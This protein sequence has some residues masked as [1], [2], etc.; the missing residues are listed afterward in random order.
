MKKYI[1]IIS[2]VLTALTTFCAKADDELRKW[3]G[4]FFAGVNVGIGEDFAVKDYVTAIDSKA[5]AGYSL[6]AE[7]RR[8]L[9][10]LPVDLGLRLSFSKVGYDVEWKAN[11]NSPGMW[12][13]SYVNSIGIAAVGDWNFNRGGVVSP[14]VGT[15]LGIAINET[16]GSKVKPLVMPRLGIGINDKLRVSVSANISD[17]A[18]NAM[19]LTVGYSFGGVSAPKKSNDQDV[20]PSDIRKL[21]RQRNAC[22]WSGVGSVCIGMPTVVSGLPLL[23]GADDEDVAI[24]GGMMIG[25]G[26]LVK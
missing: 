20:V 19:L 16:Y 23:G 8:N 21:M 17:V 26:G 25:G 14:F 7:F 2:C 9:E 24:L 22:K 10:K 3:E 6:G 18:H 11:D 13:K 15:G 1:L 5:R 12:G 4:E